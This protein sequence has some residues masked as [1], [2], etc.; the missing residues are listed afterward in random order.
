MTTAFLRRFFAGGGTSTN[1]ANAMA[2]TDTAFAI[3]SATGWPGAP[4]YSGG[5]IVVIDRGTAS[6]EKILCSSNSGTTVNVASGGRGYDG[7][8]ATAHSANASV[9]LTGGAIDFNEANEITNLLGN[10]GTT[11]I[12]WGGGTGTL[13]TWGN[14]LAPTSQSTTYSANPGDLVQANASSGA[15]TVT[16]PITDGAITCVKKMDSSYTHAVTIVPASGHIDGDTSLLLYGQYAGYVFV[17]DGTNANVV[18]VLE[19][20][21]QNYTPTWTSSGTAPAIGN[22]SV[23]GSFLQIGRRIEVQIYFSAGSTTT[24]G[25]GSY[26]FSLPVAAATFWTYFGTG[27]IQDTSL[28]CFTALVNG[29]AS[30][31]VMYGP[32]SSSS[33]VAA[34]VAATVPVTWTT[35]NQTYLSV[36]YQI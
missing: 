15:F 36:D 33:T 17:G 8:S 25:S 23:S 9:S 10:G 16:V 29:G 11:N 31:V 28:Y 22:G 19:S 2:S 21:W 32:A 12:L 34:R 18:G 27:Q 6:E 5:F 1:L 30:S 20:N 26:L 13:P 24:F 3:D 35:I 4:G 7:T 14:L